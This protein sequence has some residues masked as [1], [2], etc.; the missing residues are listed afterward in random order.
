L[1]ELSEPAAV[2]ES[3]V[4]LARVRR[5]DADELIA[6]NRES[7]DYHE[8]WETAFKDRAHFDRWFERSIT[9]RHVSLI[10]RERA[11]NEVVGV[12]NFNDV[13]MGALRGAYCGYWG[14]PRTGRR[15]LMTEALR[16]AVRFGF[17][18]LG[19]HRIEANIQPGNARSLALARRAGFTKEGFSP[20]YLFLSGAWRDH[21]RWAI[22]AEDTEAF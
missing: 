14:Y 16:A 13:V 2:S 6:L 21:E 17:E 4:V 3:R 15:G 10:A 1:R 9:G 22:L 18:E 19:L 20:R 7:V 8:P 11:T 12:I 5:A